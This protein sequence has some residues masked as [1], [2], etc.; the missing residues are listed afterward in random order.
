VTPA[1]AAWGAAGLAAGIWH[2]A[3]LWRAARTPL[4]SAGALVRLPAVGALL[5]AAAVW[6][7]IAWAASGWA[8]GLGIAA[9]WIWVRAA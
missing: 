8:A 5:V 3:A 1:A 4:P 6:G 2:A 9:M 7:S